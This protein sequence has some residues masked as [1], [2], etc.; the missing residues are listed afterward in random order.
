VITMRGQ[1]MAQ[2]LD[3]RLLAGLARRAWQQRHQDKYRR[4]G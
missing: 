3:G 2:E 1:R 4:D